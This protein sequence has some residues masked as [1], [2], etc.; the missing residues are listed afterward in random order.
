MENKSSLWGKWFWSRY[1][2]SFKLYLKLEDQQII[3]EENESS[4]YVEA[5]VL[6]S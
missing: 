4:P 6:K 2:D 3:Y 1:L 5:P